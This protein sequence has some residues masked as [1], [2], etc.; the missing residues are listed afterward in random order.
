MEMPNMIPTM[1]ELFYGPNEPT[2]IMNDIP[3]ERPKMVPPVA[4]RFETYP[5]DVVRP[6][7]RPKP[8]PRTTVVTAPPPPVVSTAPSTL[9]LRVP[10]CC[11][12]CIEKVKKALYE[13]EGVRDVECYQDEQKVVIIGNVD[14]ERALRKVRRVKKKSVY[15]NLATA[16]MKYAAVATPV[17]HT[18]THSNAFT[19]S[20]HSSSSYTRYV[21]P[22]RGHTTTVHSSRPYD[23]PYI[24]SSYKTYNYIGPHSTGY[25]Y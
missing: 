17:V 21:S 24:D 23:S 3:L 15:W 16:P 6:L 22:P 18:K 20:P 25:T 1:Q 14:A 10:L 4:V 5:R 9:E 2:W 19:N 7:L 11:E 8:V 12:K 13:V